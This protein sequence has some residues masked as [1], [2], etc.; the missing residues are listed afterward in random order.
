MCGVL[1]EII[2]DK[3]KAFFYSFN[4]ALKILKKDNTEYKCLHN[5]KS[6]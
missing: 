1:E 2:I 5:C 4:N 3:I 6:Q